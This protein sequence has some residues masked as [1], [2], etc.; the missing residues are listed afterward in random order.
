M[1]VFKGE[2]WL[3]APAWTTYRPQALL[4]GHQARSIPQPESQSWKVNPEDLEGAVRNFLNLLDI[5]KVSDLFLGFKNNQFEK[6]IASQIEKMS[7]QICCWTPFI[8][9]D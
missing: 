5:F 6:L 4:A 3:A 9:V 1:A 2:V 7:V 8:S